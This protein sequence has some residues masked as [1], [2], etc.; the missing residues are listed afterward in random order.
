MPL[1]GSPRWVEEQRRGVGHFRQP[2]PFH[3]EHADLVGAAEAV[4]HRP[5]DAVLMAALA[6][7]AQHRVDHMLEHARAGDRPV[8]GD[9]ADQDHRRSMLLGEAHQLLRRGADLADGSGCA[10]DQVGMHRL[11]RIDDQKRGRVAVSHGGQDV[12][13]RGRCRQP[14]GRSAEPEPDRAEPHLLGQ[15]LA[16]DVD[17]LVPLAREPRGDLEQQR[18]LADP[19]I[20]ADQHRRARDNSAA[21]RAVELGKAAR[22]PLRKRSRRLEPDQRDHPAAAL[23][24]VL[25]GEDARHFGRFLNERVPLGAVGTLPLPAAADG[26]AC[27]ADVSG[28]GLGHGVHAS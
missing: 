12:A 15:F 4:L 5:Q 18:R 7:E 10:L 24:I 11:D 17:D 21:D 1:T 23:E 6:F 13:Y 14:N 19:R 9:M 25:G 28:L 27:L 3:R 8:F 26:A 16:R 20:A 22:Q 2:L